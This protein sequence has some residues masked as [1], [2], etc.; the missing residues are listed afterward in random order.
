MIQKRFQLLFSFCLFVLQYMQD[1]IHNT[2]LKFNTVAV[3]FCLVICSV[4]CQILTATTP[5]DGHLQNP[6]RQN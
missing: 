3:V 2:P 4:N 1:M 5:A 6:D